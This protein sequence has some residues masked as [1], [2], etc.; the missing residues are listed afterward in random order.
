MQDGGTSKGVGYV[1]RGPYLKMYGMLPTPIF[2]Y[3]FSFVIF[4]A[5]KCNENPCKLCT[6]GHKCIITTTV[7]QGL[8]FIPG[9]AV[10][11]SVNVW[12]QIFCRSI[13]GTCKR[14]LWK[15]SFLDITLE[16]GAVR[17]CTLFHFISLLIY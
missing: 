5:G 7:G 12:L 13:T 6:N 9:A 16:Y 10:N 8:I 3:K 1:Q 17:K 15:K 4:Y 2:P 14:L 11:V